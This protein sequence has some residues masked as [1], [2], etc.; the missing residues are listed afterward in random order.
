MVIIDVTA[1]NVA[2]PTMQ[3][4]LHTNI[5]GLQWVVAGY[6]LTLACCLIFSGHLA[7]LLGAKRVL[8]SGLF[9]FILTSLACALTP[10]IEFLIFFRLLQG[11]AGATLVPCSLSLINATYSDNPK[12]KARKIG[13]WAS[14]GGLAAIIGPVLGGLLTAYLSWRAVFFIN[15]PFGCLTMLLIYC[16]STE[17]AVHKQSHF[18]ILGLLLSVVSIASLSLALIES[19]ALGWTSSLV[20]MAIITFVISLSLFILVEK[21][22]KQPMLPLSFFKIN[23]F[24]IA[25]CIGLVLNFGIYGELFALPLYF[26]HVRGYGV[27]ETGFA[28][29]P[30]V[31]LIA[32]G[33]YLSG[34]LISSKGIKLPLILGLSVGALGFFGLLIAQAETPN[35]FWLIFPLAAMGFGISFCQP[36]A[37]I[38][39]IHALPKE[40]AGLAAA[41]FTTSRQIGSLVGVALFGSIITAAA[42]FTFGF[43][44]TLI[45]SGLAYLGALMLALI[46]QPNN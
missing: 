31:I 24:T 29:L 5:S 21:N 32:L 7:D 40:K 39:A 12:L 1:I 28:L 42:S 19:G 38:A 46:L 14:V 17:S 33:S 2:L 8:L 10:N 4:A 6:T 30:L 3:H 26:Q 44:I 43:H 25:V 37:T 22:S 11:I 20:M 9:F 23:Q 15:L 36:A 13:V 35:Y 27:A 16:Y 18:D 34:K 41:V 45:I